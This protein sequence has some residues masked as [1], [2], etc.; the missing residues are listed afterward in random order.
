MYFVIE[1]LPVKEIIN[2]QFSDKTLKLYE[3]GKILGMFLN[4]ICSIISKKD[5]QTISI[6]NDSIA[7]IFVKVDNQAETMADAVF[8]LY[9]HLFGS[10]FVLL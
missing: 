2:T 7:E 9:F 10:L 4:T 5:S 1:M 6:K 3:N 8:E